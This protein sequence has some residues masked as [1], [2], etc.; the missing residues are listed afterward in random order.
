[1]R[2][3]LG[4]VAVKKSNFFTPENVLFFPV[5]NTAQG[6]KKVKN[7]ITLLRVF[8]GFF[9]VHQEIKQKIKSIH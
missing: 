3:W 1:M 8:H 5:I 2:D 6:E 4:N 9:A 7:Q